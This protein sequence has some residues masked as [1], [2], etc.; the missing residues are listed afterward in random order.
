MNQHQ[1]PELCHMGQGWYDGVLLTTLISVYFY[2][3]ADVKSV[4]SQ[5]LSSFN[6]VLMASLLDINTSLDRNSR[7]E[8]VL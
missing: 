1:N 6:T 2:R 7:G 8:Y 4:I 5:H 3:H